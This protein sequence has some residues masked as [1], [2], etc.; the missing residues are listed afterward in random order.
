MAFPE[1]FDDESA[2]YSAVA[3]TRV[4]ARSLSIAIVLLAVV[5]KIGSAFR[6]RDEMQTS[7]FA[8][9]R[10]AAPWRRP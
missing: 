2:R 9:P 7:A 6:P 8:N 1:A 4:Y 3:L 10:A 5:T